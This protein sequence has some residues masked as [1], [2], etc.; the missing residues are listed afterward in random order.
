MTVA[1]TYPCQEEMTAPSR[2]LIAFHQIFSLEQKIY[3][4]PRVDECACCCA[5]VLCCASLLLGVTDCTPK[6]Y[7]FCG[8]QLS[9]E[10]G[11]SNK[12]VQQYIHMMYYLMIRLYTRVWSVPCRILVAARRQPVVYMVVNSSTWRL[13]VAFFS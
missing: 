1:M 7:K 3:R 13:L 4:L 2:A 11:T 5:R 8:W 9:K 10:R 12:K 6:F